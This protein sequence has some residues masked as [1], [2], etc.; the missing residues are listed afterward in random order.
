MSAFVSKAIG[1]N[2]ELRS[3]NGEMRDISIKFTNE[4]QDY[5]HNDY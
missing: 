5:V 3:L 2:S 1:D 4:S